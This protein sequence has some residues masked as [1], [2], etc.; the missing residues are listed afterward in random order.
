MP[1]IQRTLER[2][3]GFVFVFCVINA[4]PL[5]CREPQNVKTRMKSVGTDLIKRPF[6]ALVADVV[7][8]GHP[9]EIELMLSTH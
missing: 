8:L 5:R 3:K 4:S 6:R 9:R 7:D 1:E 2:V